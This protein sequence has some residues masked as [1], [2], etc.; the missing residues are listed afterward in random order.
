MTIGRRAFIWA[1]G[2]LAASAPAL[3]YLS[4]LSAIARPSS[5]PSASTPSRSPART[6]N[7]NGP[8]FRIEGWTLREQVEGD[9]AIEGSSEDSAFE[10]EAA[11]E[12]WIKFNRSW[13]TAWR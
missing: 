1:S 7:P 11:D 6:M 9:G 8:V 5:L 10:Y 4:S 12:A 2:F 13:R 3:A